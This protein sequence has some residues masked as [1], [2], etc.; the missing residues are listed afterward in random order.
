MNEERIDGWES[1][2]YDPMLV[3]EVIGRIMRRY[4]SRANHRYEE[5][6]NALQSE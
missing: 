1:L 2:L 4:P 6:E 3:A 5:D